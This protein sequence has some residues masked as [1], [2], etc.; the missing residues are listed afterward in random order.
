MQLKQYPV[1]PVFCLPVDAPDGPE[2]EVRRRHSLGGP[3]RGARISAVG[4]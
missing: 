2:Q 1:I 4:D 3:K